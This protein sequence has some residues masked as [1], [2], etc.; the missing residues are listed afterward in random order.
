MR[1]YTRPRR[2]VSEPAADPV[3]PELSGAAELL[4]E[5]AAFADRA[6]SSPMPGTAAVAADLAEDLRVPLRDMTDLAQVARPRPVVFDASAVAARTWAEPLT[7][8]VSAT[9]KA[10]SRTPARMPRFEFE[11][12]RFDAGRHIGLCRT[13]IRSAS[14]RLDT[15]AANAAARERLAAKGIRLT[16]DKAVRR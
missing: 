11:A 9:S 13:A 7:A 10:L 16:T 15:L 1:L 5:L 4:A 12:R 6:A 14:K 2:A 8:A 3:P